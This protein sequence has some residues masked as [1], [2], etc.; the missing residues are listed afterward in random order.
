MFYAGSMKA[1]GIHI[2]GPIRRF[3]GAIKTLWSSAEAIVSL[4][5][6]LLMP[7]MIYTV[8]IATD[9]GNALSVTRRLTNAADVIAQILSQTQN[10][11]GALGDADIIQAFNSLITTVP[12]IL[13]SPTTGIAGNGTTGGEPIVS[14]VIQ[15]IVSSVTFGPSNLGSGGLTK[16]AATAT[17]ITAGLIPKAG[18]V[19]CTTATVTWS[20]GLDNGGNNIRRCGALTQASSNV[21]SP[22]LTALPPGLYTPGT[23]L[24]VDVIYVFTPTF[25]EWITGPITFQRTAYFTPRFFTQLTYTPSS[26][27]A[28]ANCVFAGTLP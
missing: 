5:F 24:V 11:N 16:P 18:P 3:P 15:P 2:T 14:S 17:C 21:V 6:A 26:T 12:D 19:T 27:S 8:L 25:T 1:M 23:V 9:I 7:I 13:S 22:S 10:E 20:A 28:L 4:E